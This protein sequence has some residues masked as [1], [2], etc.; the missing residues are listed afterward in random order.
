M[1][2][3][4]RAVMIDRVFIIRYELIQPARVSNS[5]CDACQ[6]RQVFAIIRS[7]NSSRDGGT[8]VTI[9]DLAVEVESKSILGSELTY[10]IAMFASQIY[11]HKMLVNR[12]E[13]ARN[14]LRSLDWKIRLTSMRHR[15]VFKFNGPKNKTSLLERNPREFYRKHTIKN[16]YIMSAQSCSMMF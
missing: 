16:R 3:L 2:Q 5:P 1:L 11:S 13:S 10:H 9:I 4:F 8:S 12:D 7:G 14:I 15:V 6:S